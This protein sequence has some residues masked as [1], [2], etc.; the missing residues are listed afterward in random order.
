MPVQ[1]MCWRHRTPWGLR[2]KRLLEAVV[3]EGV[4][5]TQLIDNRRQLYQIM[6][7]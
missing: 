2:H 3:I 5:P 6:V 4:G 7:K 1:G